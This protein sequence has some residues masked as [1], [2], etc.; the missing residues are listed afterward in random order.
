MLP[1]HLKLTSPAQFTRVIRG[2]TRAGTKTLVAHLGDPETGPRIATHGGPRFGLVVSK[3]VGD[4]VTRHRTSR[5]LRHICRRLAEDGTVVPGEGVVVRALPAA[6]TA[7]SQRLER[8]L[9]KAIAK[10][11]GRGRRQAEGTHGA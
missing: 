6:G 7:D 5:R 4:A 3:A 2:G 1:R 9:R 11:R 8:D 10:A